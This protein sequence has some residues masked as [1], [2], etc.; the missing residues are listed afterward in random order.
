MNLLF[1]LSSRSAAEGSAFRSDHQDQF[2]SAPTTAQEALHSTQ[3]TIIFRKA[4]HLPFA[5]AFLAVIPEG[6]LRFA[7]S[8]THAH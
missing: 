4:E 7:R 6:N 2:D 5:S 8:V 3:I 1:K